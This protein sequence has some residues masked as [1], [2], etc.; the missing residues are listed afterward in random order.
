MPVDI[1]VLDRNG[2]PVTDLKQDD[3]AVLENGVPQKV[4]HFSTQDYT[5]EA[6]GP[7]VA[8]RARTAHA[9]DLAPENRRVFLIVLGRG[10]LQ[11]PAKGVD[12]MVHFVR[13]RL[14][15]QD[16]VAVIAWNR[17]TEFTTNHTAVADLLE[18]FKRAHEGIEARQRSRRCVESERRQTGLTFSPRGPFGP[19]P[20]SNVT[21]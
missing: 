14:L 3:F 16:L 5:P 12:G 19:W 2:K 17:A 20:F 11:P 7:Q 18:R 6:P 21:A 1:R 4:R 13:E 15:P 8:L 10:R 9:D